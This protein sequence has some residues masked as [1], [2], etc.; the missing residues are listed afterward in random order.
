MS[1]DGLTPEP[2]PGDLT[3]EPIEADLAAGDPTTEPAPSGRTYD[4]ETPAA[5]L[6]AIRDAQG[7]TGLPG[8]DAADPG[9]H[10]V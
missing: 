5:D 2:D 3:S 7:A 6:E 1:T 4:D 8:L 9:R 10:H